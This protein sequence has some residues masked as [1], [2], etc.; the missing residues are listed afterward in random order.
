[1]YPRNHK[2]W[3]HKYWHYKRCS[4]CGASI[5]YENIFDLYVLKDN[6][7]IWNCTKCNHQEI[8]SLDEL[9]IHC[10]KHSK[11]SLLNI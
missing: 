3:R 1:M 10:E 11:T 5:K 9:L 6:H 7:A 4:K 8:I 2:P